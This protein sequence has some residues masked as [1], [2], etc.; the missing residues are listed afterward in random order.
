M[1][2]E[3]PG[4]S[5]GFRF[6]KRQGKRDDDPAY[7]RRRKSLEQEPGDQPADFPAPP[8]AFR[9]SP[10]PLRQGRTFNIASF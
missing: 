7:D 3:E 6:L 5:W 2:V 8:G 1:T 9:S 4:E 10:K